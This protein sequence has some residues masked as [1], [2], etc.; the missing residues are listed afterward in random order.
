MIKVCLI[1]TLLDHEL[2]PAVEL[3]AVYADRWEIELSFDEIETH[4][5]GHDRVLRSRT[6]KL[7][8]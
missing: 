4:Q 2:A 5:T 1:T 3:A 6:P 8:K 7:V